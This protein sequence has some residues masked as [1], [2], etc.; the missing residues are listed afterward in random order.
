M[1]LTNIRKQANWL[2]RK[3][4]HNRYKVI[5]MNKN[6]SNLLFVSYYVDDS[7]DVDY[8]KDFDEHFEQL[9]NISGKSINEHIKK[10]S[11]IYL[12][13]SLIASIAICEEHFEK[14]LW[15]PIMKTIQYPTTNIFSMFIN[16]K[17]RIFYGDKIKGFRANI[18]V[19]ESV[20]RTIQYL[21][22]T[23][24][25]LKENFIETQIPV[26]DTFPPPSKVLNEIFR[27][28]ETWDSNEY[29]DLNNIE[30]VPHF[31]KNYSQENVHSYIEKNNEL[32][33]TTIA[34]MLS[35]EYGHNFLNKAEGK[36]PEYG[37]DIPNRV[38]KYLTQRELMKKLYNIYVKD[39]GH[40]EIIPN[41]IIE[42]LADIYGFEMCLT[43][44]IFSLDKMIYGTSLSLLISLLVENYII[45]GSAQEINPYPPSLYRLH[46]LAEIFF[47]KERLI[48]NVGNNTIHDLLNKFEFFVYKVMLYF[49]TE[50][51]NYLLS[52]RGVIS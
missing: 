50:T 35:H 19:N 51:R 4:G 41:W 14:D 9:K 49:E 28:Y 34:F 18:K 2:I 31:H 17:P 47:N 22:Q 52:K 29:L 37:N 21:R 8:V 1:L 23:R 25:Y 7:N 33:L 44:Q 11:D 45:V 27:M 15:Y 40:I 20:P 32:L 46:V 42:H 38:T 36:D 3:Y 30:D 5:D 13:E 24:K 26:F 6:Q 10:S 48:N 39:F 16:S 12:R 43:S